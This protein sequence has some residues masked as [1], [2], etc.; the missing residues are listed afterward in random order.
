MNESTNPTLKEWV[1][2]EY[3]R[4]AQG[5]GSCCGPSCCSSNADS[6]IG[7]SEQVQAIGE[8]IGY[9]TEELAAVPEG[10][11]LGLGCGNPVALAELQP[12]QTVLDLGCGA[13]LDCFLAA[14]RV[15]PTGQVIGVDMTPEMLARARA[16]AETG[17][18][19]NVEFREGDIEA[20]PVEDASVDVVI[21]NCVLNLVPDKEKAFREIFR[22]LRPGGY[23]AVSDIV[24]LRDLPDEIRN[25]PGV[26]ASC[27]GG[28]IGKD[29]YLALLR[30]AGFSAVE[31]VDEV[32]AGKLLTCAPGPVSDLLREQGLADANGW[33]ASITVKG[34]KGAGKR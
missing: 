3:G 8:K 26:Y 20:L 24:L 32:E 21:S 16:N 33:A 23:L 28:A 1:R 18:Y 19:S 13:G 22:V 2:E 6:L 9:S 34:R 11:N 5:K 15:G 17:G 4:T 29:E 31:V 27:I 30:S 25:H 7:L 10:A 14:R 12:G